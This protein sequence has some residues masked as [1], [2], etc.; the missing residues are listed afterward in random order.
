MASQALITGLTYDDLACFPDDGLRRELIGGELIVSPSPQPRHQGS[1]TELVGHL[2]LYSNDH[3]G[4]V[5]C[6]LLDVYF[7][8]DDVV[9]PDVLYI[10]PEH[11][12]RIE[13][14][15]LR[16]APDIVVEVSS[17]STRRTDLGRKLALY[18]RYGVP[19]YWYV[20]LKTDAIRV[21][22]LHNGAYGHPLILKPGD[23]LTSPL[24]PGFAVPIDQLL[25]VW[26][27]GSAV[28]VG[29]AA[30]DGPCHDAES[31]GG[32]AARPIL[33]S[34]RVRRRGPVA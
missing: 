10:R 32:Q 5:F 1:V 29:L 19:E 20:D 26:K 14:R 23:T 13:D 6:A 22:R 25:C 4:V 27:S 30:D 15:F 12:H 11:L 2:W 17:P 7:A 9:E 3:G 16:G 24:L 28:G 8:H 34:G 31:P 18:E 21:Y 33:T